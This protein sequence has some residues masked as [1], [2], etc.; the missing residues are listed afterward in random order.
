[1]LYDKSVYWE[2]V[3]ILLYVDLPAGKTTYSGFLQ[4]TIKNKSQL[5]LLK[6]KHYI[7]KW[8]KNHIYTNLIKNVLYLLFNITLDI[9]LWAFVNN[10]VNMTV[11][12]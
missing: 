10:I 5:K 12:I 3:I 4:Y 1:M 6:I 8:W 2:K 7:E 11:N 9:F